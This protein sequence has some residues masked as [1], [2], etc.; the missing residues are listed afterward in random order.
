[1]GTDRYQWDT[2]NPRGYAN[3][4]GRY[5]TARESDF[6]R[7]H[8]PADAIAVLDIGGGSGRF[9]LPLADAGHAMTVVDVSD[10]AISKLR[11]RN[12]ARVAAVR[13]EFL[14]FETPAKFDGAIAI[15]SMLY[16]VDIDLTGLFR[17]VAALLRPDAPFVFT[18]LN[19]RSWRYRLHALR[20]SR[21]YNVNDP[22]GYTRALEEAGFE[23]I[24]VSG[25]MWMPLPVTSNSA[26]V[27]AFAAV[28]EGFGLRKW[29][30]QSPWLLIA[31][32]RK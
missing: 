1:V 20:K 11:Q 23:V 8:L 21:P 31:A 29:V 4:M 6:I 30:G 5:K 2:D 14:S 12:H 18:A 19:T 15:E 16:F 7:K 28:E 26:A 25:F 27:S 9:A 32:R 22:A 24:E 10:E 17:K 3:A 13:C